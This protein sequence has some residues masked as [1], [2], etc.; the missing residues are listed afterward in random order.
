METRKRIYRIRRYVSAV[1][2]YSPIYDSGLSLQVS[3]VAQRSIGNDI[4]FL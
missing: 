4:R 2:D 1:N 3:T